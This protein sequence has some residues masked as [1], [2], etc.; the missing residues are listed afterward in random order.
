M[1]VSFLPYRLTT[2]ATDAVAFAGLLW[3][4]SHNIFGEGAVD[5]L[6]LLILLSI[7]RRLW[8]GDLCRQ[9]ESTGRPL[10]PFI[11]VHWE[12]SGH[13]LTRT[14]THTHPVRRRRYRRAGWWK[15]C[16]II[17]QQLAPLSRLPPPTFTARV[18]DLSSSDFRMLRLTTFIPYLPAEAASARVATLKV[19]AEL[20]EGAEMNP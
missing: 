17:T 12:D 19:Q 7:T 10:V 11:R 20:V 2:L 5:G 13:R 8:K 18:R 1:T 9:W 15:T 16:N 3:R 14:Y 6:M 4:L